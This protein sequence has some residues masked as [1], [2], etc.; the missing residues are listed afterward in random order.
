MELHEKL[1][2]DTLFLYPRRRIDD[3]RSA[4]FEFAM[5]RILDEN[6]DKNICV[7]CSYLDYLDGSACRVLV[8]GARVLMSRDCSLFLCNLN[9]VV[10]RLVTSVSIDRLVVIEENETDVLK[11]INLISYV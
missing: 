2:S 10:E 11:A 8:H 5:N 6:P 9:D 4:E 1:I 7:N 3:D